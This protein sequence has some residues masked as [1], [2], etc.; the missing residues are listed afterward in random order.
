LPGSKQ[1]RFKSDQSKSKV[2]IDLLLLS[3]TVFWGIN[4]AVMKGLYAYFHPLAFAALRFMLALSALAAILRLM[5]HPLSIER[6]DL[7]AVTALGIISNT[8]YQIIFVIG[9]DYTK[10]GNAG[11][12]MAVTP[13]FAYMAGLL[14]RRERFSAKVLLG[15]FLSMAGVFA[16]VAFGT[17]EF[18][19]GATWQGDLMIVAAAFCWGWYSGSTV[20][21]VAKYGAIRLTFWL[22]LTGTLFLV[23]PLIPFMVRQD[24]MAIPAIGWLSFAYSTFFAIVYCYLAWSY[25]IKHVGASRT[26]IYA[27]V[28]P[29]TALI[30]SWFLLGEELVF[31]QFLGA[32]LIL[33]GVFIVRAQ[34]TA[35]PVVP[36]EGVDRESRQTEPRP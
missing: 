10:A 30:F 5:G 13:V 21:L 33:T 32:V 7:P 9:L 34:K 16:I 24:W 20:R 8:I 4:F 1:L 12:I 26:A 15:I 29:V 36:N 22:M 6:R 19:F 18:V 25:A 35:I 31:A 3:V 11:L 28:T 14:L 2:L 23:P 27:N 17:R